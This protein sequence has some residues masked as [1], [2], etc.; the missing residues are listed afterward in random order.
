VTGPDDC[1]SCT[2]HAAPAPPQRERVVLTEHWH[3]AHAFNSTLPGWLV[4]LPNRHVGAFTDLTE[5]EAAEM[6]PL[7]RRLSAALSEVTGCVKTYLMQF[8]EAEGFSHLHLHL[9]PRG[10]DHP[11]GALGPRVFAFLSEDPA[12]WLG[13]DERDRL[14]A[15]IAEAYARA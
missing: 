7:V 6:G 8:S 4:L 1:W 2:Q 12:A 13:E 14:G 9:V 10:P 15:R 11:V 3:A 5:A